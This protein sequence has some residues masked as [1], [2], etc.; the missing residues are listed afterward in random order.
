MEA[1]T[2]PSIFRVIPLLLWVP[3]GPARRTLVLVTLRAQ[4]E[5]GPARPTVTV[6]EQD[7]QTCR[8]CDTPLEVTHA[9][10]PHPLARAVTRPTPTMHTACTR[11]PGQLHG[12]HPPRTRPAPAGQGSYRAHTHHALGLHPLARAV[13]G[14][15]PTMHSA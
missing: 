13:T 14:P 15:T 4:A 9:L 7:V 2:S 11:W 12:P 3:P 8:T 1:E 10:P 5:G 6:A